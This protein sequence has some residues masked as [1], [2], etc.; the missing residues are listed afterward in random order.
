MELL[1]IIIAQVLA[2]IDVETAYGSVPPVVIMVTRE[3]LRHRH[4]ARLLASVG[5]R[6][7]DH[8]RH[9]ARN[10][11]RIL[12]RLIIAPPLGVFLSA[13][14]LTALVYLQ[15]APAEQLTHLAIFF[16]T[17]LCIVVVWEGMAHH[18]DS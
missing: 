9:L 5:G 12:F 14:I 3:W 10:W 13:A 4:E 8:P 17:A 16:L 2:R 11:R 1:E 7:S 18:A 15:L 6:A